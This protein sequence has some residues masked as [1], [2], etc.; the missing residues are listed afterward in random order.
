MAA[1]TLTVQVN[2]QKP[3]EDSNEEHVDDDGVDRQEAWLS[4]DGKE[5]SQREVII[6]ACEFGRLRRA[7][8]WEEGAAEQR[9]STH[10]GGNDEDH[11][12]AIAVNEKSSERGRD[13]ITGSF[14]RV[15]DAEGGAT[16]RCAAVGTVAGASVDSLKSIGFKSSPS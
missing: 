1:T 6:I 2:R 13:D 10:G 9:H 15:I 12:E 8:R 5:V 11:R 14:D 3:E 16:P 7:I 4:E